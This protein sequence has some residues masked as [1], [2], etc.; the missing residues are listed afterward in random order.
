MAVA[1]V[2]G[3]YDQQYAAGIKESVQIGVWLHFTCNYNPTGKV[4]GAR[5]NLRADGKRM[6]VKST[7]IEE[8]DTVVIFDLKKPISPIT[9]EL[10]FS[11][12]DPKRNQ[13]SGVIE[14]LLGNDMESVKDVAVEIV[15]L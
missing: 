1:L 12:K 14:D 3:L 13:T 10:L 9:Q 6:K 15:T 11:Y 7:M 8:E 4:K 2:S 5:I